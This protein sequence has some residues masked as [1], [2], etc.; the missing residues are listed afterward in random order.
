ML[1][2]KP[3]LVTV[4][5]AV[6]DEWEAGVPEFSDIDS[7]FGDGDHGFAIGKIA[8]AVRTAVSSWT[9]QPIKKT[10]DSL[11]MSIMAIG[12][13][14]SG[15]LYG[16][17]FTGLSD[18]LAADQEVID[19]ASFRAMLLGCRKAMQSITKAQIGQKTM[20]DALLPA[21]AA[22]EACDGDIPDITEAARQAAE[23]G[24]E[25]TKDM[26]SGFGRARSYGEQTIGTPD[27][28]AMSTAA[29]FRGLDKGI[30]GL[31]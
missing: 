14:S 28:G 13:G 31:A 26:V 5:E 20:M 2:Q 27:A 21:V 15:P 9:D 1:L 6:A 10:L 12:G 11:G 23:A 3:Q 17:I 4:L 19:A 30:Q 18:G 22:A 24:A 16:T 7:K 8:A 29:L 25:S